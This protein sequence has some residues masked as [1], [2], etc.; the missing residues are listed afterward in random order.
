MCGC[1]FTGC[2]WH[3]FLN[4]MGCSWVL[5]SSV[6]EVLVEWP[7][8][9]FI[10]RWGVAWKLIPTVIFLSIWNERNGRI[11]DRKSGDIREVFE[12]AKWYL[13]GCLLLC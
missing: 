2:V 4:F 11:F 8:G 1:S 13:V 5:D 10:G 9:P 6:E 3:L 12:K 7:R